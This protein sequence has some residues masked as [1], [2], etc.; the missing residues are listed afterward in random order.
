MSATERFD[1]HAS[2][3]HDYLSSPWGRLL[4]N[5]STANVQR[6]IAECY[7]QQDQLVRILD[8]G[9][10][11][12][13]DSIPFAVQGHAVSILDPSIELLKSA[14]YNAQAA[15]V[16]ERMQFYEADLASIPKLFPQGYFDVILCHNV[17]QY[18]SDLRAALEAICHALAPGGF[19]STICVNRYSEP[20]RMALQQLR[21]DM[22]YEKLNTNT[23]FSEV[24]KVD[25]RAYTA[26]EM[27]Q[28]FQEVGGSL[29]AQYGLRC[30]F[31]YIPDNDRKND[32]GFY[33]ELE[34]LEFAMSQMYPYYLLARFFQLIV[35]KGTA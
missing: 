19:I 16:S 4:H 35:R 30:V 29:L 2:A 10:G 15:G 17:L 28:A 33:A 22:A 18:V 26:E 12:G 5:L 1:A 11:T 25:V 7:P 32:P 3:Y 8:V 31:D 13:V 20:Y 27:S 23:T 24:V 34:R 21:P 6:H 9:G 14:R